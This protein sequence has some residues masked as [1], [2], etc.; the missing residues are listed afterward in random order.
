MQYRTHKR[1][2]TN[3]PVAR[4][5]GVGNERAAGRV[6]GLSV[7]S[8]ILFKSVFNGSTAQTRYAVCAARPL[9]ESPRRSTGQRVAMVDYTKWDKLAAEL[10][11]DYEQQDE[12]ARRA[13]MCIPRAALHHE[14]RLDG[15]QRAGGPC[16]PRPP[17]TFLIAE[18]RPLP[19]ARSRWDA[20]N[21]KT[22][23]E[24]LG[25][26]ESSSADGPGGDLASQLGL[27]CAKTANK[28]DPEQAAL[29]GDAD[30]GKLETLLSMP[31]VQQALRGDS[32]S[33][34]EAQLAALEAQLAA[35]EDSA[36]APRRF[37][38][39]G[40]PRLP[41]AAWV[42]LGLPPPGAA[43]SAEAAETRLRE[44]LS[45]TAQTV[46]GAGDSA[47]AGRL[48]ALCGSASPCPAAPR[49]TRHPAHTRTARQPT[50]PPC[51]RAL[52]LSA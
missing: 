2:A 3:G 36:R 50:P 52:S 15:S 31:A 9:W 14:A 34:K 41:T 27:P 19:P 17:A 28:V 12:E 22:R 24:W 38:D 43:G 32:P 40:A 6:G 30:G 1:P 42:R 33:A 47:P 37:E 35:R 51:P 44:W 26:D 13:W 45:A 46:P 39:P 16:C 49:P 8:R 25:S 29:G 21:D 5:R 7:R 18:P 20:E 23:S 10:G 11:D 4:T 48:R